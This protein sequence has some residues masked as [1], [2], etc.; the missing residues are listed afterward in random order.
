M[1]VRSWAMA[2]AAATLAGCTSG[3]GGGYDSYPGES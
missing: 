3:Y 2:L 1:V